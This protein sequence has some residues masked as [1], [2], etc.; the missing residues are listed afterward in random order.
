[1]SARAGAREAL[2]GGDAGGREKQDVPHPLA[3][4]RCLSQSYRAFS[5]LPHSC[6]PQGFSR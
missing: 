1:M 2:G 5:Q 4:I 3:L 6:M